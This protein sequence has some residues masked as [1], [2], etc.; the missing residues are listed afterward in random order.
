MEG[1]LDTI[2]G[3]INSFFSLFKDI[4]LPQDYIQWIQSTLWDVSKN[5]QVVFEYLKKVDGGKMWNEIQ[6][7]FWERYADWAYILWY[8]IGNIVSDKYIPSL[9]GWKNMW[10]KIFSLIQKMFPAWKVKSIQE[11]FQKHYT[12]IAQS[13]KNSIHIDPKVQAWIQKIRTIWEKWYGDI[14]SALSRD[15]ALKTRMQSPIEGVWMSQ[16]AKNLSQDTI[17][18]AKLLWEKISQKLSVKDISSLSIEM[19]EKIILQVSWSKESDIDKLIAVSSWEVLYNLIRVKEKL[20][21]YENILN[22]QVLPVIQRLNNAKNITE[23]NE[24]L[25][26]VSVQFNKYHIVAKNI[27]NIL[28]QNHNFS[29]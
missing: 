14:N 24:I 26:M 20:K 2:E 7:L 22:T 15:E 19:Y 5:T 23:K 1:T 27:F 3:K 29:S 10:E 6:T 4:K 16:K 13:V 17:E 28:K 12:T 11:F 8:I 9:W 18:F 25:R 21:E